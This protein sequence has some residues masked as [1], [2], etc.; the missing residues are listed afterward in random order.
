[1]P[2][3]K[4]LIQNGF[5]ILHPYLAGYVC[6]ELTSE[7]GGSYWWKEVRQKLYDQIDDLPVSGTYAEL[8]DSL[9][10]ANCLRILDRFWN[11]LFKKKLA[12]DYRTWS[13]ELMGVRNKV[14]HSGSA[15]FDEN[16][17]WRALDT[18]A[19]L[20]AAFDDQSA[21][22]IR[23]IQR[24]LRYGSSAGSANAT[25]V[26]EQATGTSKASG[27]LE[28]IRAGLPSW[29]QIMEPHPDVA[30]GRYQLAEFAANLAQVAHGEGAIEYR[31]PVE[32]FARTYV[33]DGM[34]GLLL[35]ALLRTSGKGGEPVIQLK[36]SFGGGKTHSMLALYH[37]FRAKVPVDKVP[38]IKPVLEKAGLSTFVK[39][40]VA[41]LV[42]FALD[43]S[44]SRRPN[45]LPGI[46]INTIWGEMAAQLA[47]SAGDLSLYDYVKEADKK[48][49]S[50]G[51]EALKNL[52]D[53]CGPCLILMDELVAYGKKLYG[54]NDL[55]AGTFDNFITFIQEIT[56]A[57]RASANSIVVA[58]IPES[59]IEVGGEAGKYVLESIE[60]T[61]GRMESIWKPVAANEGFEVVR[62][63]LFLQC[64]DERERD[65]ICNE[66]SQFYN[67]NK[68]DFPIEA[69]ELAYRDRMISC[70][71]IHPE[72]FDRLYDD[73]STLER[74]QRTR[75]VLRL[76][77]AV[78][79]E[80]WMGGDASPMIMPGSL[81]L[82]VANVSYE[83]TR[84]LN[85]DNWTTI[86][87][88]EVDGK[89]SMPF[90]LEKSNTRYGN[91]L[92]ARRVA[93]TIFLGSA[94][95]SRGQSAKGIEKTRIRL[96][97]IQPAEN[98]AEFNDALTALHSS[99]S[100]LYSTPAADRFWYDTR[101]T[102]RKTVEERASQ[103]PK[104][105]V[106]FEIENR[107]RKLK[108]AEPFAGIHICPASSLDIPDEQTV[109]VVVLGPDCTYKN[110]NTSKAK[111]IAEEY[112]NSR[113]SSPRTYRNT[114]VFIAPDESLISGLRD[115]V[116]TYLAW[117]FVKENSVE[118]N[119]DASQNR[120]TES[121]LQRSN[122]TVD[123]RI[124]EAYS[125]LLVPYIDREVDL[126]TVVWDN[127]RISG[128]SE[129]IIKKAT[130]QVLQ[131]EAVIDKWAPSLLLLELDN[132]L[133]KDQ[134]Y[135]SIKKLWDFLCTY[136]YLPRIKNY[137]VLE[138][139]I[140][141]GVNSSEFFAY[142]ADVTDDRFVDLKYNQP[143]LYID[144]SGYLVKPDAARK[145][146]LDDQARAQAGNNDK[147]I[148]RT[149][150]VTPTFPIDPNHQN[151]GS[152]VTD[153]NGGSEPTQTPPPA[154][155]QHSFFMSANIDNTRI[156][157]DVQKY[158]EE[159]IVHLLNANDCNVE[160]SL[161]VKASSDS[162]FSQPTVRAVS[163]N[164]RT[165]KIDNFGFDS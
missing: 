24:E 151:N 118:L 40:N 92:I 123:A 155:L 109:R 97:A 48:G 114:L 68:V 35:Q 161:E 31:D 44:K 86:I 160:I 6:Q 61:F 149:D 15:D 60:H 74:F 103:I 36:T 105:D 82:D 126:R 108:K 69:S 77:A 37:M 47:E 21:E 139:T 150:P 25:V 132:L 122:Q 19:L 3:N 34:A 102:L 145:Q 81:P 64:K 1:M 106:D 130:T 84:H 146:I 163:E 8:M 100:Y 22:E 30:Q 128:S 17:T 66:Y 135:L 112:L 50:P 131:R 157:R 71:P 23:E 42:G 127:S 116:K 20:C 32:F 89:N 147:P 43:P 63:R 129:D 52:F 13:K 62:R 156:V 94:P 134:K 162:G 90:Q 136:C 59:D 95:T 53:A 10:I 75:G 76:M 115:G 12:I 143:L 107:L 119:L 138:E 7:Y 11:E 93:R 113:G 70:Y 78:I 117:K 144:K 142:A 57:A 85:S 153:G 141:R 56:E 137:E 158:V 124:R 125:W 18:M 87:D 91:R 51:S 46:T 55:P 159:V 4:S 54:R 14:S 101:P 38:N 88:N 111:E 133:W 110:N 9:D 16:Y 28:N 29:R 26:P 120:E 49:V 27:I 72:I 79:H 96:G 2:S 164:C 154:N 99:L 80:L 104:S 45:N 165:L 39:A 121:N 58:S 67:E 83:L 148:V 98:I 152:G 5:N 33:T 65:R 41:V 73:W 140:K